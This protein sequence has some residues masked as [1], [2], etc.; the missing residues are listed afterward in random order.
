MI[1]TK[2]Q[3]IY[4]KFVESYKRIHIDPWHEIDEETLNNLHDELVSCMDITDSYN[5]IYFMD[6]IIKRLNGKK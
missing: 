5:F 2:Y 4:E 1:S 3:N 6:Y